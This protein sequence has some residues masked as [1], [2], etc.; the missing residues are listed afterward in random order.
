MALLDFGDDHYVKG[1]AYSADMFDGTKYSDVVNMKNYHQVTFLVVVEL[2]STGTTTLTVQATDDVSHTNQS[3]VPFYVQKYLGTDDVPTAPVAVAAAG[4]LTTAAAA[5]QMY[6]IAVDAAV[7]AASGYNYVVLK[8]VE[9][10]NDPVAGSILIILDQARN[11]DN[12]P[13]SAIV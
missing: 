5:A 11:K 13:V 8:A 7:L 10:T 2:G 6:R 4:F 12:V 9:G 1:A 3:A